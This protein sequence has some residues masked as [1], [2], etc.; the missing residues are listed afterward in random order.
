MAADTSQNTGLQGGLLAILKVVTEGGLVLVLK[1]LL[2]AW[3]LWSQLRER[4][5]YHGMYEILDYR[6]PP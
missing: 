1:N 3:D 4:A 5:T 2:D 6:S